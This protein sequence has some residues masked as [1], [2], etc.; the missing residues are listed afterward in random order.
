M[1]QRFSTRWLGSRFG[2]H[3][4]RGPRQMKAKDRV[5]NCPYELRFAAGPWRQD[6]RWEMDLSVHW[7][8]GNMSSENAVVGVCRLPA[9][10]EAVVANSASKALEPDCISVV[11]VGEQTGLMPVAYYTDCGRLRS[12]RPVEVR[13]V[14]WRSF[15][16]ARYWSARATLR[17]CC[18]VPSQP[19][20]CGLWTTRALF[21]DLGPLAPV[22]TV[23]ESRGTRRRGLRTLG[24]TGRT[25]VVVH[26]R[27][28]EWNGTPHRGPVRLGGASQPINPGR[29][30]DRP[31]HVIGA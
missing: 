1:C 29:T 11:T 4:S 30:P 24:S 9:D 21:G 20:W 14:C 6:G 10:A 8:R 13:R 2:R 31:P 26:G 5:R 12:T 16:G 23:S 28:R 17:Y 22:S 7:V 25:L 27:A 3:R 18:R 15:R 19:P